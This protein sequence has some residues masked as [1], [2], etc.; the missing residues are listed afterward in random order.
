M[1]QSPGAPG[2][3][4]TQPA[5]ANFLAAP[6]RL[7]IPQSLFLAVGSR[8]TL[9]LWPDG[10]PEDLSFEEA[11]K[12]LR[13]L[14]RRPQQPGAPKPQRVTPDRRPPILCHGAALAR[15]FGLER[16]PA[17]DL[18]ELFAFVYP[19]QFC[20][21]TVGGLAEAVGLTLGDPRD[22]ARQADLMHRATRILL[23][24]LDPAHIGAPGNSHRDK[25]E[26][27]RAVGMAWSLHKAGWAW[28]P[29]VLAALGV[30]DQAPPPNQSQLM[31]ALS[32]WT[33]LP[34][35]AEEMPPAPPGTQPI[36]PEEAQARLADLL[37]PGAE[38]RDAQAAYSAVLS[39]AFLPKDHPDQPHIVL[40]E[41][42]T[43]VGKT[44]GYIAPASVWAERNS[45]AVWISTFTRN[46][47]HQID[48]E[49]DRL[50]PDPEVKRRKVV[51]RKGREN[52]LCLLN[53]EEAVTATLGQLTG[54]A[55][56]ETIATGLMVRWTERTGDGALTGGDFP[57][58]LADVLGRARSV[59]LADRRGECIFSACPHY[60]CCFVERS[61][62]RARRADIV[63]AN[64]ALVM[65]QAALGG[66][67][68]GE[69]MSS[70]RFLPTRYVFD[71]GHHLFTAADSAFSMHLD[72]VET[73]ELRRWLLGAETG[74]QSRA[75]GLRR[76][77]EDLISGHEEAEQAL[78]RALRA[79]RC[80]P[81]EGW[82]QRVA[83]TAQ[84]AALQA[85]LSVESMQGGN[86]AA[87][88]SPSSSSIGADLKPYKDPSLW[89][90]ETFLALVR[91]QSYARSPDRDNPYS[92]ETEID[93][94]IEGLIDAARSLAQALEA[95]AQPLTVLAEWMSTHL[96]KEAESLDSQTRQRLESAG[97]SI[98]RRALMPLSAWRSMILS[99]GEG[100]P[101]G[102]VDWFSVERID[103]R[104]VNI[105]MHRH[106][107][108][109]TIPF[110]ESVAKQ[111]HGLAVTSATLTDMGQEPTLKTGPETEDLS[112]QQDENPSSGL[113]RAKDSGAK[114]WAVARLRSGAV[115]LEG[116]LT[117]SQVTSPF[118]YRTATKVLIINDVRKDN[119]DHVAAAYR[120]L[121]LASRGG[122]LGLF[123]AIS[124]LRAV[125]KRILGT[126]DEA[127]LSLFAQHVDGLDAATLVDMF[128]GDS[129]AC[130]L[131]T[132][133]I[134]DGVDVPGEALR[135]IIFDRVP[136]PRPDILHKAR[137]DAHP[138]QLGGRKGYDDMITR[139]RLKQA[140][141]RLVRREGDHGFFV[142]LDP[143]MPSRLLSAFPEGVEVKRQGLRESL[144]D[145]KIFFGNTD[146]KMGS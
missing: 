75:R 134:R 125:H 54:L 12:R 35:W 9:W 130:L 7:W 21:P 59:N 34:E 46:L 2:S 129:D 98:R 31:Q 126:L 24:A 91:Q 118:A 103:G 73:A 104:D 88:Q 56:P 76:R 135:L 109:P 120:T 71:E 87:A 22:L 57:G 144:N 146:E 115:H 6:A 133:A 5:T 58:W 27:M 77:L 40:A 112:G 50:Y 140:F 145:I 127:G 38:Q 23:C 117:E 25:K 100:T 18:L 89:A 8:H 53:L 81:S 84:M 64:H 29:T 132:D 43:G 107:I 19:A 85:P 79:A 90:T 143:M 113:L 116:P 41:A 99:L 122:A 72:G 49:L 15:R 86:D 17:F 63:V 44:L 138:T 42:G 83:G 13:Q 32:V 4:Q 37:G 101:E 55:Q 67:G 45:G 111:A 68:G 105:G 136:W 61:V 36:A 47:Q 128:K 60:H 131:G 14:H 69:A 108:D 10:E 70:E 106:W 3:V 142:L 95:I 137:R 124:R 26:W 39:H 11:T 123:T 139:L 92:L 30:P 82:L 52:Y 141:G 102:F 16:F 80:L 33:R 20:L 97:I 66:A 119:L 74:R 94:V 96:D 51:L 62:R 65:I 48:G 121:M 78:D 93:P 28:G 110:V 114:A 1:A